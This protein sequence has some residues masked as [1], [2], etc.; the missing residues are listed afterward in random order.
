MKLR[1]ILLTSVAI[2]FLSPARS[3]VAQDTDASESTAPAAM[4]EL[5]QAFS[6]RLENARF[7]GRWSL[8]ADGKIGEERTD[9]YLINSATKVRGDDWVI[10]TRMR[11]GTVDVNVPITVQVKWAGDTPVISVSELAIPN[12]GTYS[13]RVVVDKDQYGGSWRGQGYGGLMYGVI[14]KRKAEPEPGE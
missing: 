8:V 6:D 14:E 10:V 3:V 5:E 9:E 11:F 12:V 1:T 13:A 4:N 2:V 7:T